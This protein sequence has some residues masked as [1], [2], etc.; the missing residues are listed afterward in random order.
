M[1]SNFFCPDCGW[2]GD[3]PICAVCGS[4]TESLGIDTS[5]GETS[6]EDV[7]PDEAASID[8]LE[9]DSDSQAQA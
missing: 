7:I 6:G 8:E 5:T 4:A 1:A 2:E 9:G 3:E